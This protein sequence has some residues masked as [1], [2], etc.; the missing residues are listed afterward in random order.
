MGANVTVF[1][2]DVIRPNGRD[3]KIIQRD[4]RVA[5]LVIVF[6]CIAAMG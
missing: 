4:G 2:R 3:Q 1:K 6:A 5:A